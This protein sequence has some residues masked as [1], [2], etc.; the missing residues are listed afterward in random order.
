MFYVLYRPTFVTLQTSGV[1]LHCTSYVV[2]TL[3]LFILVLHSWPCVPLSF[4]TSWFMQLTA[5]TPLTFQSKTPRTLYLESSIATLSP[6][7]QYTSI[8]DITIHVLSLN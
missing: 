6:S 5:S 3:G 1:H 4:P 2:H 8:Q 7:F